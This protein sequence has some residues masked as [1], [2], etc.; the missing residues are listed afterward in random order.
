MQ[1]SRSAAILI[2]I[3]I[4]SGACGPS[5]QEE[6]PSITPAAESPT[7]TLPAPTSALPPPSPTGTPAPK[8][9]NETGPY[10]L[11]GST[12]GIWIS[13]PDGSFLTRLADP[14][15]NWRAA[16][17]PRISPKG[18]RLALI[19]R[20]DEGYDLVEVEIPG[21]KMK[22]IT[23]LFDITQEEE[24]SDPTSERASVAYT[25]ANYDN[26]AWQPGDGRFL[27][28]M[29]MMNGPSS[30]LYLYDTESGD[31]TQ[32]TSGLTQ[33]VFPNWSP[34]GEYILHYGLSL[35]P[36]GEIFG[37]GYDR[38]GHIQ[39][40]GVWAVRAADGE[41]ITM[42]VPVGFSRRVDPL[43]LFNL[44]GWQDDTHYITFDNDEETHLS[45]NLRSVDVVT[46]EATPIMDLR[47]DYQVIG[48]SPE[49][50]ALLFSGGGRCENC[51]G[52]GAF[53]LLPGQTKPIRVN[54]NRVEGAYWLPE[55]EVFYA[56]PE[57]VFSSD[58]RTRYD[59]PDSA[60]AP[61]I[62]QKGYQAWAVDEGSGGS[63][64]V[65]VPGANWQTVFHGTIENLIWDPVSG[66]TLLIIRQDGA[67]YAASYPDFKPRSMGN[68][69][70]FGRA[71][72]LP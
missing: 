49:N 42:P 66:E 58:G 33:A 14:G 21:G 34:N 19:V 7:L 28:F 61:A 62:S 3:L 15:V 51:A 32:L 55:S 24:G 23:R 70:Y 9:L 44:V 38:N 64:V 71:I 36:F 47:F 11:Y 1:N 17:R 43:I 30:D 20:N 52:V 39:L 22:T 63:V 37:G 5:V 26:L 29:G 54:D 68:V 60:T 25:I 69:G 40:H 27:A 46:G 18:D 41:V 59:S 16:L 31:I 53:V 65:K 50:G 35:V 6:V 8:R 2:L 56:Y 12:D 67:V 4:V 10:I 45:Q 13:N 72:W 57:A 48:H